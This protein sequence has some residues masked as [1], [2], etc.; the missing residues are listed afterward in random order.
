MNI[1]EA[2]ILGVV[3][4]LT[5]FLPISSSGHLVL[6]QKM[7]GIDE[8]TILFD[9]MLHV[10]TLIAVFAVLWQDVWKLLK[11][12]FQKMTGLLIIATIPTVIFALLFNDFIEDAFHS[13]RFLGFEFLITAA[14]LIIAEFLSRRAGE[15]KD[16]EKMNWLDALIIGVMQAL[17]IIPAVSRSGMTLSGAL[18]RKLDRGL[19]ARFSFLMSIPAILGALV[20]QSKDLIGGEVSLGIG[21]LPMIAGVVSAALVGFLAIRFMLKIVKER[22]LVGFAIYVAILGVLIIIDQFAVHVFF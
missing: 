12:P 20:F 1:F 18:S 8:P 16:E 7:L 9:T 15:T 19:A 2:I 11:K 14:A 4:G 17:S 22:S 5:E 21:I 10:G 13:A 6:L 3:Q